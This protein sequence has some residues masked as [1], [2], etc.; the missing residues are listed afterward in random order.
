[1]LILF[2]SITLVGEYFNHNVDRIK[3]VGVLFLG[4]Q[5]TNWLSI[6]LNLFRWKVNGGAGVNECIAIRVIIKYN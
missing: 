5:L 6:P 4:Q 3:T 2:T 1:M